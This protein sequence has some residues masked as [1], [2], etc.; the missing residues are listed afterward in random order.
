M[1]NR[2][3]YRRTKVQRQ[4]EIEPQVAKPRLRWLFNPLKHNVPAAGNVLDIGIGGMRAAFPVRY[5]IGT[6]CDVRIRNET[7]EVQHTTGTVRSCHKEN[8]SKEVGIAFKEPLLTLGDPSAAGESV[9]YEGAEPTAV[10]V[11][12]D[13]GV[14]SV[15]ERFLRRRGLRVKTAAN[16]EE[17]LDI[18]RHEEPALVMIDLKMPK[19]SGIQL[20]EH[21]RAEGLRAS[22]VWAMSGCVTDDEAFEALS[23]GAAEFFDKPF[24]LDQLDTNLQ[25]LSPML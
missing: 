6:T 14:L 24:D 22:H 19:I 9:G 18:L 12:D 23:M 20:L 11:D 21:M 8:G 25:G 10:V 16:G 1:V 4:V 3:A 5:D 17:A 13:P 2:R 7:G 15:L